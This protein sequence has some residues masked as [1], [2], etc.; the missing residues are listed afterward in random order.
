MDARASG[1]PLRFKKFLINLFLAAPPEDEY[2]EEED[3]F[4][5][6]G[7]GPSPFRVEAVEM[8]EEEEAV[9]VEAVV[10]AMLWMA[11]V[12]SLS[13]KGFWEEEEELL[14]VLLLLEAMSGGN[15][16]MSVLSRY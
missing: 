14:A 5:V 1:F 8:E 4:F 10:L 2:D 9:H 6:E 11:E 16:C 3:D 12:S 15:R 7:E 13:L